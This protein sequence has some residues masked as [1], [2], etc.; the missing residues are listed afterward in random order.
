MLKRTWSIL[1]TAIM[2][3]ACSSDPPAPYQATPSTSPATSV[4]PAGLSFQP[5]PSG[6]K[7]PISKE[8]GPH[9]MTP[10]PHTFAATPQGAVLAA[11]TAQVW[12]AGADDDTW[13]KVAEYLLEPG[14]GRDQW[15]QARA[16]VSVK[17]MVK[18]PAEFIGFKFTSYAEDK[19]IVLLAARWADGMLTAYPVQLSSLTGGWRVVIPPQ[20]SE[21]DLSEISDTDLDTFV[22]FNP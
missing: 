4:P 18:N 21:P 2:L 11:V 20:G 3:A 6:L 8:A 22:R 10:V 17:G 16:L 12:M 13:P 15:A 1:V 7:M 14:L 19:A 5:G 9:D